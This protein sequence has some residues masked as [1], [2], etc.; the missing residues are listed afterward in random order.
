MSYKKERARLKREYDELVARAESNGWKSGV[1]ISKCLTENQLWNY[2][3]V[4]GKLEGMSKAREL[5]MQEM[6]YKNK[7]KRKKNE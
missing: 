4:L 6:R 7:S 1:H 3:R 5:T 2:V